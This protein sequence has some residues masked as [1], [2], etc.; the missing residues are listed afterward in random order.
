MSIVKVLSGSVIAA[1]LPKR[2]VIR[3]YGSGSLVSMIVCFI[4]LLI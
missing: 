3:A 2:V 4:I 1:G